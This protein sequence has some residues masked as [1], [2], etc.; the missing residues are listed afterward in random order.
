MTYFDI[1]L[2]DIF[3][4]VYFTWRIQNDFLS[5]FYQWAS[6]GYGSS[7]TSSSFISEGYILKICITEKKAFMFLSLKILSHCSLPHQ[8][9]QQIIFP[10]AIKYFWLFLT[11]ISQVYKLKPFTCLIV[12]WELWYNFYFRYIC[13]L[14]KINL[15]HHKVSII[16]I[17]RNCIFRC[18]ILPS[19]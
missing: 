6:M 10:P 9:I 13:Y 19:F 7:L 1:Y 4:M 2:H 14:K 16:I 17:S 12:T 3:Y 5:F 11:C 15:F 18:S 8:K